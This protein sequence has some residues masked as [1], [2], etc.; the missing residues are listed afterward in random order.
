MV[1]DKA[2][3]VARQF[4]EVSDKNPYEFILWKSWVGFHV[5]NKVATIKEH[6]E[7]LTNV[8]V[9]NLPGFRDEDA[10]LMGR[11]NRTAEET[12]Y[13]EMSLNERVFGY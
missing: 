12:D 10:I 2:A 6:N 3:E 11:I 9:L 5:S 13:S 4:E 1:H 7:Y 8:Q